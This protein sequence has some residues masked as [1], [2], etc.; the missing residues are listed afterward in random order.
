M[1]KQKILI[2][3]FKKILK[4]FSGR[5]LQKY[6]FLNKSK[7]TIISQLKSDFAIVQ[8]HKMFLGPKDS[9]QLSIN[10]I[11]EELETNIVKKEIKP[12]DIILDIGANIGYYTLI[13]ANLVGKNGKVFAFEPEP[14]NFELLQKNIHMNNY[15]N[16]I[17]EQKAVGKVEKKIDL[18]L[19][20]KRTGMHR[21][22]KSKHTS[23]NSVPV[24]MINLD[25]YFMNNYKN[26][27]IN[28]IKI[29]I[30]GSEFGA[31]Q[32][33][34]NILKNENI[35]LLTEFIPDSIREFG[36][37]PEE[38]IKLLQSNNFS[39]YCTDD[40]NKKIIKMDGYDEIIEKFPNGTNLFCK[41]E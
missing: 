34:Q 3:I 1:I 33:L 8:G 22:Y 2:P 26:Q 16:I 7:S 37:Y 10:G 24:D 39:I 13:F 29:D 17:F 20:E 35:K 15:K 38:F 14:S 31:L 12:G 41:K 23:D 9:L 4:S 32:G 30:E 36:A 11:Y 21:I 19:S 25:N 28:F 5:G 18:Y 6:E 40:Q 27:E